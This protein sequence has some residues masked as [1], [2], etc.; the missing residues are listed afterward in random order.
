MKV[1]NSV[2]RLVAVA[3]LAM[4]GGAAS[5]QE[6][7]KINIGLASG[8]LPSAGPR[9]AQQMGLFSKH[10]LEAKITVLDDSSV[11]TQALISG[12][13]DFSVTSPSDAII[14][15]TRGQPVLAVATIYGGFTPAL[16]LSKKAADA[17]GVSP[18][19]PIA[20]RLKALNGLLIASPSAVSTFTLGTKCALEPVGASVRFTYMSQPAM[21][22]AIETGAIQGFLA[23]AP[24]YGVPIAKGTGVSWVSGPN[25]EFPA[26]CSTVY[27]ATLNATRTYAQANPEVIRRVRAVLAELADTIRKHPDDV[28]AAIG[29]LFPDINETNL[30]LLFQSQTDT[31][32]FTAKPPVA[33]GM[34]R[35]ISFVKLSGVQLPGLDKLDP[36]SMLVP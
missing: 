3:C 21:V 8:S 10:G 4:L 15:Q 20:E 30:A 25:G 32:G 9:I 1:T 27:A 28:K 24:F 13:I 26:G 12:S 2:R 31:A 19:A 11:A 23:S 22:S 29:K 16:V 6:P 36:V 14:A 5:A 33:D 35:E 17:T 7:T 34:A 18:T